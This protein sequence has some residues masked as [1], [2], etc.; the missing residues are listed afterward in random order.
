VLCTILQRREF[1]K[2][3]PTHRKSDGRNVFEGSIETAGRQGKLSEHRDKWVRARSG[4]RIE[5]GNAAAVAAL[6]VSI[7]SSSSC[8]RR[9]SCS[10]LGETFNSSFSLN[11]EMLL[12]LPAGTLAPLALSSTGGSSVEAFGGLLTLL[13]SRLTA[14]GEG[15]GDAHDDEGDCGGL[16]VS[17][18]LELT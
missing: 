18:S 3:L 5:N 9:K 17:L 11:S 4:K 6:R 7:S 8:T 10:L 12:T 14:T 1:G 2:V 15:D 16:P 13:F